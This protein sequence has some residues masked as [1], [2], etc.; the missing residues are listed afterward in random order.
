MLKA[1]KLAAVCA[2]AAGIPFAVAAAPAREGVSAAAAPAK[3][4]RVGDFHRPIFV[5][6]PPGDPERAF[7]V[8]R[9]GR[10]RIV[11]DGEVL[12]RDFLDIHG[13]VSRGGERGLLS[14]AFDADYAKNRRFYVYYSNR[15]GDIRLR[16]FRASASNPNVADPRSG[17]TLLSI[18]HP[19]LNHYGGQLQ[20]G[21]DG[22]L[23]VS[24]G[25]GGCCGNPYHSAQNVRDL[26][27]KIL[28]IDPVGGGRYRIPRG[29]PYK[30]RRE[31]FAYG[32]RNPWRF[33][34]DRANGAFVLG[35]VGQDKFEEVDYRRRGRL[36]GSNFGWSVFEGNSRYSPGSARRHVRPVLTR[37][38]RSGWCAIV[39]GYVMRDPRI[40]Q[41]RGR[42][43]YGDL[44]KREIRS[45][46]LGSGRARGDAGTGM[47]V[48]P[49]VSFGEDGLGRVYAVSL[50]GPVYRVD[51][52]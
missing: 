27:G 52:R 20:T 15:H 37:T 28:R 43:L 24:T 22:Y 34:F 6:A 14:M 12:S 42:Y 5:T 49:L 40:P 39:G 7:V 51:P 46:A 9:A 10:I 36:R 33:S 8:E 45:V 25:D 3:L 32:L 19:K 2:C 31:V 13:D 17:R 38:H 21:P 29:N 50:L 35:E 44:C 1:L 16:E 48:N 4:V 41:L 23:Y 18:R 26:R 47:T 30:R 11:R